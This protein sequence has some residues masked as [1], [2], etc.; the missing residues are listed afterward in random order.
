MP[1]ARAVMSTSAHSI[2]A[3]ALAAMPPGLERVLRTMSQ[4]RASYAR[5]SLPTSAVSRSRTA[6]ETA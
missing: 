1:S 3:M 2:P 5:G 6:P 4:N